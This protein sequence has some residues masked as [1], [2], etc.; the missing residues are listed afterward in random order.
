MASKSS[1]VKLCQLT[2]TYS[3]EASRATV[4]QA[5]QKRQQLFQQD[6]GVPVHLKGGY[7]DSILYRGTVVSAFAGFVYSLYSYYLIKYRK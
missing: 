1:L 6:N 4:R 2:R 7:F 3:T 5:L